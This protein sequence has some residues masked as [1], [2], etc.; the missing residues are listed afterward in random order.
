MDF[1]AFQNN[2]ITLNSYEDRETAMPKRPRDTD[3]VKSLSELRQGDERVNV[4]AV[5]YSSTPP[6]NTR[7][8]LLRSLYPFRAKISFHSC[9]LLIVP[10]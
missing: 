10:A 1:H 9:A 6:T 8:N 3:V 4:I 7:G 5:A 2:F